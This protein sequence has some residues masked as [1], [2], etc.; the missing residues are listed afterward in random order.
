MSTLKNLCDFLTRHKIRVFLLLTILS[1][2]IYT[3]PLHNF[4]HFLATGDHGRELYC[5]KKTMEGAVPYH[6]YS[7]LA[8]PLI[9]YSFA[10]I[11]KLFGATIQSALLGQN[12]F[13][14]L[15]GV[16]IYLICCVFMYPSLAFIAA[17]FYWGYRDMEFFYSYEHISGVVLFLC[18]LLCLFRYI[19]DGKFNHVLWGFV[20]L[21]ALSLVRLHIAAASLCAF[22][23]SILLIDYLK[24]DV[25]R[26]KKR[27]VYLGL[28]ATLLLSSFLVY[29]F[30]LHNLASYE[31]QQTFP[32][33]K[34]HRSDTGTSIFSAFLIFIHMVVIMFKISWVRPFF[35]FL[36]LFAL[37]YCVYLIVAGKQDRTHKT[38]MTLSLSTLFIFIAFILMEFLVSST[39]FRLVWVFPLILLLIF[40]LLYY[41]LN[42]GP[43]TIFTPLVVRLIILTLFVTVLF[44]IRNFTSMINSFKNP[45]HEWIIGPNRIYTTQHQDFFKTVYQTVD[46]LRENV[47]P[48][49]K[50]F[51]LPH[52]SLYYF[53]SEHDNGSRE[54]AIF[55]HTQIPTEQEQK[56]I[57]DLEKNNVNWIVVSNR[58][59]SPEPG[60]GYFG[61]THCVNLGKYINDHFEP[62]TQ[63]GSWDRMPGWAWDH[64]T[65]IY[66]RKK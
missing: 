62:A 44:Q 29:W 13:I 23:T 20:A 40:Y 59:F 56:M 43:K 15:T 17:L 36:I 2:I 27:F 53:L 5:F 14:I 45:A 57:K 54:L 11:F 25:K 38:N 46:Y 28:F 22:G 30:L 7:W 34:S 8:G 3:W 66:K 26:N 41:L 47:P 63:F 65:R 21:F 31:I 32:Y 24:K 6:D 48:G 60:M 12:L 64:G 52:D 49:Q 61:T 18:A 1:G 10:A 55:Q 50:I 39:L 9:P 42:L 16:L 35:G 19:K 51:V 4:Q 58:A 33:G 37:G